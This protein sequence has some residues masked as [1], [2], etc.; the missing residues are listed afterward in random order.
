MKLRDILQTKGSVVH[1]ITPSATL[2]DVANILV[3]HNCGSLVVMEQEQLS[4]IITE[5]D[6]LRA[7]AASHQPLADFSVRDHM[8][9]KL[10]TGSLDEDLGEVMGQMTDHRIRHLPVLENGKL[11]G[12]ISIGDVV[13]R[14]TTV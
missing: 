3:E 10:V 8:T 14:N 4:G 13:K 5:R 9:A 12:I 6:I 2:Q 7:A 1:T 11:V